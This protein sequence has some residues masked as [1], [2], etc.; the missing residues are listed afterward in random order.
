MYSLYVAIV[1]LRRTNIAHAGLVPHLVVALSQTLIYVS[2]RL[3]PLSESLSGAHQ[4]L[5]LWAG[6][7]V[8]DA[9]PASVF[10]SKTTLQIRLG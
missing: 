1:D 3:V 9:S 6:T 5:Q 7:T 4:S 2:K 10:T 8:F